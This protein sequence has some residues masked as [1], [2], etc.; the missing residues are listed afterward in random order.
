[1]PTATY[2]R[3]TYLSHPT[4]ILLPHYLT[5]LL[6]PLPPHYTQYTAVNAATLPVESIIISFADLTGRRRIP[7]DVHAAAMRTLA[8]VGAVGEGDATGE[9]G[10]GEGKGEGK[11]KR[12]K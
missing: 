8:A 5:S 10:K 3:Y 1:M 7:E 4:N 6:Y 2:G 12:R 11:G 9:K